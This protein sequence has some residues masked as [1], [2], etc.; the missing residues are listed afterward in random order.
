MNERLSQ[1][2]PDGIAGEIVRKTR[3]EMLSAVSETMA[4][5]ALGPL[6]KPLLFILKARK[7]YSEARAEALR[8]IRE[9]EARSI[10]GDIRGATYTVTDGTRTRINEF[11]GDAMAEQASAALHG[12]EPQGDASQV[13]QLKDTAELM[14]ALERDLEQQERALRTTPPASD[15]DAQA[16]FE[17]ISGVHGATLERLEPQKERPEAPPVEEVRTEVAERVAEVVPTSSSSDHAHQ[18]AG[19][20]TSEGD[21]ADAEYVDV[22]LDPV[23][24]AE[25]VLAA[26]PEIRMR[27]AVLN[28]NTSMLD[29]RIMPGIIEFGAG[30]EDMTVFRHPGLEIHARLIGMTEQ[31]WRTKN[32]VDVG[33]ELYGEF[34]PKLNPQERALLA[35]AYAAVRDPAHD[36]FALDAASVQALH[37]R[38][39]S[40]GAKGPSG[41]DVARDIVWLAID[42]VVHD[43]YLA[44]VS[45]AFGHPVDYAIL[46]A[47]DIPEKITQTNDIICDRLLTA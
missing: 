24:I 35:A 12:G 14:L 47:A 4:E 1:P 21:P 5:M 17:R 42:D 15:S 45:A 25:E 8:Q 23:A 16:L 44:K 37:A 30:T 10:L 38:A 9:V 20:G 19:G 36:V 6:A 22:A 18:S 41:N 13:Q 26:K 28:L 32:W 11:L 43:A 7:I 40:S 46:R 29:R 27:S 2:F 33:R 34:D 3:G 39:T 31:D